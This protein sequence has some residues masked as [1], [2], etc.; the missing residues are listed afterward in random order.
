MY[1]VATLESSNHHCSSP[2]LL[3]LVVS[4]SQFISVPSHRPSSP[5]QRCNLHHS[6]HTSC[7]CCGAGTAADT[8]N[9]TNLISSQLELHRLRTE[10]KVCR[11]GSARSPHPTALLRRRSLGRLYRSLLFANTCAHAHTR[12]HADSF[13]SAW[14]VISLGV[15]LHQRILTLYTHK[16]RLQSRVGTAC[17]MLKQMLYR[18]QGQISAALVLGGV[19]STGPSL[20]V[21]RPR[22]LALVHVRIYLCCDTQ[23]LAHPRAIRSALTRCCAA[24]ETP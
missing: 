20:F 10:R 21:P 19:D 11:I 1:C 12:T 16:H 7:S 3:C 9:S 6:H 23:R 22:H 5:A 18:Y 17:R 24:D 14:D 2:P 13:R 4:A 8:E 15:E